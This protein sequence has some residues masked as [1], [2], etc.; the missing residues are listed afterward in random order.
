MRFEICV[1]VSV[2]SGRHR[3]R[4]SFEREKTPNVEKGEEGTEEEVEG[5]S[6]ERT[7]THGTVIKSDFSRN[8]VKDN[9]FYAPTCT[10]I[11][12]AV[13]AMRL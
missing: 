8:F 1:C 6:Y 4:A 9:L 10:T 12:T 5:S 3:T 2:E 11:R 7:A 13:K